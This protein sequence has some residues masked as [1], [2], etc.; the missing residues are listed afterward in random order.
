MFCSLYMKNA[1]GDL[2]GIMLN[3][4]IT[5]DMEQQTGSK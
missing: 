3:A 2:I 5:K 1:I 4:Y